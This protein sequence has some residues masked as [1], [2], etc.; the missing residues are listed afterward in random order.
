MISDDLRNMLIELNGLESNLLRDISE[1]DSQLVEIR[2]IQ[3]ELQYILS[4][5]EAQE[6]QIRSKQCL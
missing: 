6:I 4:E 3:N 5:V 2:R 1:K